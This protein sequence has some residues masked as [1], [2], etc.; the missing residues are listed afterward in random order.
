MD[1]DNRRDRLQDVVNRAANWLADSWRLCMKQKLSLVIVALVVAA[2]IAGAVA[3]AQ[4]RGAPQFDDPPRIDEPLRIAPAEL[5]KMSPARA[6]RIQT[7]LRHRVRE[8]PAS[9]VAHQTAE[10]QHCGPQLDPIQARTELLDMIYNADDDDLVA[11]YLVVRD[12]K[13]KRDQ[14]KSTFQ[15]IKDRIEALRESREKKTEEPY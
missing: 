6:E 7:L 1:Q 8:A 15:S 2:V 4:T 5:R 11:F 12:A 9:S 10:C 14:L 13:A 3:V